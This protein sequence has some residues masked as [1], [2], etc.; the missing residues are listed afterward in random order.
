MTSYPNYQLKNHSAGQT[1]SSDHRRKKNSSIMNR[2]NN[3][4]SQI[5]PDHDTNISFDQKTSH[6]QRIATSVTNLHLINSTVAPIRCQ[7]SSDDPEDSDNES[8]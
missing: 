2:S 8:G 1:R 4:Q 3:V 7:H 5:H 6:Q